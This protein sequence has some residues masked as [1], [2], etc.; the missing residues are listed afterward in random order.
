MTVQAHVSIGYCRQANVA[1]NPLPSRFSET[2]MQLLHEMPPF[3][4][5][6]SVPLHVQGLDGVSL[7]G[8]T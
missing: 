7:Y 4:V 3:D 2:A 6:R 8:L 5:S 1:L